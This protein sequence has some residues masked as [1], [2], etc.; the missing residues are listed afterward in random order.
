MIFSDGNNR[1]RW[2]I[3]AGV[4][5]VHQGVSFVNKLGDTTVETLQNGDM[6][7]QGR[8]TIKGGKTEIVTGWKHTTSVQFQ[9]YDDVKKTQWSMES[10]LYEE[11]HRWNLK[12]SNSY[13]R[14]LLAKSFFEDANA[15]PVT[16]P[17]KK[18]FSSAVRF[19][20]S[21]KAKSRYGALFRFSC[22]KRLS[23]SM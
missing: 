5:G 22:R 7:V 12:D 6:R 9:A 1:N 16:P 23:K 20:A 19:D 13:S 17:L 14:I 11:G 10:K 3:K 18:A 21:H 2:N 4:T 15:L 8:A